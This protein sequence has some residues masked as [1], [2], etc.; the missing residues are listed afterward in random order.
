MQTSLPL[1]R[2]A[3]DWAWFDREHPSPDVW[4][5]TVFKWPRDRIRELQNRRFVEI[6]QIAWKNGFYRR[7]WSAAGIE[8]GDIRS[9]DDIEKLP[10]FNSDD[11]K[12]DQRDF[13][14]Y[15][16]IAGIDA[17]P[18][19][20]GGP[21]KVQTSGGTTGKARAI[22]LGAFEW[23]MI[24]LQSARA[25]YLQGGRPGDVLQLPATCSLAQFAWCY[26]KAAHDYLGIMPVTTGSGVVTP[27]RKQVE[28][29]FDFGS[30]IMISFPEYLTSIAKSC[31]DDFGRDPRELNFKFLCSFLGPD[32]EGALRR[33]LEEMFGCPV[34]DNYGC[35]ELSLV[36]VEGPDQ[37]GR[38]VFDDLCHVEILDVETNAALPMGEA[39]NI[40]A[41]SLHRT[42]PPIIRFNVRDLGR[43]VSD[44]EGALGSSFTRMDCFLGRS[45]DMVKIRGTNVY[46]MA[47]LSAVKSDPRTTGEWFCI[48]DRHTIDGVIRDELT[49]QVEIRRDGN[50]RDG[51]QSRLEERLRADLGLKVKVELVEEG[52]LTEVANIGRE[53]KARRLLD[54]RGRG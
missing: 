23:E 54:R 11:I 43:I 33:E 31:Q 20:H 24:A 6:M 32:T 30:N 21:L 26:Y 19:L 36:C 3:I 9:L 50:G 47:C 41:T 13:P 7:R 8:P 25:L 12:D 40:V 44:K 18:Y 17:K 37:D 51:L 49:V 45:D 39:G 27:T 53:G 52:A 10:T 28:H 2:S 15:G 38:Y 4:M 42:I 22:L 14:P 46:P 35:N 16:Q 34:Y 5:E 48:A 29:A 1:Y